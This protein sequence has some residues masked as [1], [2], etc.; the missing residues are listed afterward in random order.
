[1]ASPDALALATAME[2][3]S[4]SGFALGEAQVLE[5]S[6]RNSLYVDTQTENYRARK[7]AFAAALAGFAL[8]GARGVLDKM[9]HTVRLMASRRMALGGSGLTAEDV[10]AID[11]A[12][13][14]FLTPEAA[15]IGR[16]AMTYGRTSE[17]ALLAARAIRKRNE[18]IV[19]EAL[20]RSEVLDDN[21]CGTCEARDGD[22]YS[23][24]YPDSVGSLEEGLDAVPDPDCEGTL[25]GNVCRGIM[26]PVV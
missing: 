15:S 26:V 17:L 18:G 6:S 20:I 14:R 25:G 3:G 9:T 8:L 7:A 11:S 21:T 4:V 16:R 13:V 10:A 2:Q 1:M 12:A 5:W 24:I 23:D 19:L 22:M